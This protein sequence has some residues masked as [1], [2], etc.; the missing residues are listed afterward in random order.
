MAHSKAHSKDRI[1]DNL[2]TLR[3]TRRLRALLLLALISA[4]LNLT[5]GCG[6]KNADASD[7]NADYYKGA[8]FHGK[9]A[10]H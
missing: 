9:Q 3:P 8:V 7:P 10:K 6:S 5:A 2:F 1:Q 4:A